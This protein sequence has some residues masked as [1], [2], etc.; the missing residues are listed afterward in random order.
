VLNV[1]RHTR[2][3]VRRVSTRTFADASVFMP[4][5]LH[6]SARLLSD[7]GDDGHLNA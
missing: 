3:A 1:R 7:D 4:D 2:H 5:E 6:V